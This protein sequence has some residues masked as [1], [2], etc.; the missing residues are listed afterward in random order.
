MSTSSKGQPLVHPDDPSIPK[1][2]ADLVRSMV[3]LEPVQPFGYAVGYDKDKKPLW[4]IGVVLGS[5]NVE[6][7][8]AEFQKL[9]GFERVEIFDGTPGQPEK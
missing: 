6:K 8:L 1:A 5:K 2:V 3:V 4:L 9:D 7:A